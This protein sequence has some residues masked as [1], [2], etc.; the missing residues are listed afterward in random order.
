MST[1][2]QGMVLI[3]GNDS[4]LKSKTS[5]LA[6]TIWFFHSWYIFRLFENVRF[7]SHLSDFEREM[8]Y[9]TEMV[10]HLLLTQT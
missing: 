4:I 7:F 9:R 6:S 8:T 1:I 10:L 5:T 2:V 3:I